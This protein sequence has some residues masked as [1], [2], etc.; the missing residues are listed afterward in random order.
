MIFF[1]LLPLHVTD[2]VYPGTSLR[3]LTTELMSFPRK[4][5]LNKRNETISCRINDEVICNMNLIVIV[6]KKV[7]ICKIP[8][9][10]STMNNDQ[11]GFVIGGGTSSSDLDCK[12][13]KDTFGNILRNDLHT[14]TPPPALRYVLAPAT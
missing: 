7:P 8:E 6:E 3:N 10:N 12:L 5:Q 9:S 1:H 2:F 13:N 4:N 11:N 14:L